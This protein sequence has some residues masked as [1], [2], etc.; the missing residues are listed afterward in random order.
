MEALS[1]E[2]PPVSLRNDQKSHSNA[3]L[4]P[5]RGVFWGVVI[6]GILWGLIGL[7]AWIAVR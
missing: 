5:A 4:R 3:E 1:I 2:K 6:G 7:A